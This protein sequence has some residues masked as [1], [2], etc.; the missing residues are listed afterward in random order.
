[1]YIYGYVVCGVLNDKMVFLTLKHESYGA[2]VG[3]GPDRKLWFARVSI[4][5]TKD[6]VLS[7]KVVT[8]NVKKLLTDAGLVKP[9]N[10]KIYRTPSGWTPSSKGDLGTAISLSE[11]FINQGVKKAPKPST[12]PKAV[13]ILLAKK[14]GRSKYYEGYGLIVGGTFY[15]MDA[16]TSQALWSMLYPVIDKNQYA[17]DDG[18]FTKEINRVKTKVSLARLYLKAQDQGLMNPGL[19]E[20]IVNQLQEIIDSN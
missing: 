6:G 1:M 18:F 2:V 12:K 14:D 17:N 7:P 20:N 10:P 19:P 5:A 3:G 11:F 9:A 8:D 16:R 15:E 4:V 13:K